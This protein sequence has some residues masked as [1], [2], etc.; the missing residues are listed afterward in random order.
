MA[1][2]E[3]VMLGDDIRWV[4]ISFL[5]AITASEIVGKFSRIFLRWKEVGRGKVPALS[6]LILAMVVVVTSWL[7]WSLSTKGRLYPQV[8]KC[9]AK[10]RRYNSLAFST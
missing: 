8:E 3:E 10:A 1:F 6:H 7:G 4:F 9:R 2:R 5:F